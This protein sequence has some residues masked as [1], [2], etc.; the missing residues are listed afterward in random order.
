ML[1]PTPEDVDMSRVYRA[2]LLAA[3]FV[4]LAAAPGAGVDDP[5]AADADRLCDGRAPVEMLSR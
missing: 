1:R 2:S 4:V 5:C 3:A